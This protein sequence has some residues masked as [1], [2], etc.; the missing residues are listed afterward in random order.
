ME[1]VK[2]E[3][4]DRFLPRLNA[5]KTESDRSYFFDL[6]LLGEIITKITTLYLIANINEDKDRNK[7]RQEYTII[8]ANGIGEYATSIN[9]I[10]TGPTFGFLSS[11]LSD[12]EIPELNNKVLDGSWQSCAIKTM[13]KCLDILK[14][15]HSN[16]TSKPPFRSWFTLFSSLRN[17]TRGHGAP[18]ASMLSESCIYLEESL[19]SIIQNITIFKRPWAY[20]H[21]NL[22]GKYRVSPIC[23][24][25]TTFDHL[26]RN[27]TQHYE[28]GIYCH[29]D[30][31]RKINLLYSDA[32]LSNFY[33]PNG[34]FRSNT[35]EVLS[36]IDDQ[37]ERK[38]EKL[39]TIPP[40]KLPASITEGKLEL[41]AVHECFTNVPAISEEYIHRPELEKELT[42][43]LVD[44]YRYPVITLKGRGGIGK[45]SLALNIIHSLYKEYP[46]RYNIIIWFSARDV[47]LLINGPK[48][49]QSHVLTLED[50]SNEYCRLV[51]P[52]K[53][54]KTKEQFAHDLSNCPFGPALFVLDNFET[55]TNPVEVFDWIN[56]YIRNPNKVLITSRINRNFKADYP[57]EVSGMNEEQCRTL[58]NSIAIKYNIENL[59]TDSYIEDLIAESNGHPYIIKIILGEIARTRKPGKVNKIIADKDQ[60]LNALFRRTFQG[61]SP[62]AKRV[63]LTL[64]SWNSVIPKLA[65]EA[66]VYGS[67]AERIDI[68]QALDDL[69]KSSFI[70]EIEIN[71]DFFIN[72]PLAASLYGQSELAVYPEKIAIF[73]DRK[74]LMEFGAANSRSIKNGIA[75]LIQKKFQQ[76]ALRLKSKA[77]FEKEKPTLEFI[78]TKYPKA[79]LFIMDLYKS[80]DDYE[81]A[82]S[83]MREYLKTITL[84]SEKIKYWEQY[85]TLCKTT[86]D[87]NAESMALMEL[88]TIQ[89]VPF[90]IISNA[91]SRIN[92]Y[93]HSHPMDKQTEIRHELFTQL[94]DI[95]KLR[96]E[97]E[98]EAIDFSRLAWL[99]LNLGEESKAKLYTSKGLNR[100]PDDIHC[101]KLKD[102]LSI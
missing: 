35:F 89:D 95:M 6:L 26:K 100:D 64:C 86:N 88:A 93:F 14:I 85:V 76:V 31:I 15:E 24:I 97:K 41:D 54:K 57:I 12:H 21:Q 66:V 91:A 56:T 80:F 3:L 47:D 30:S 33:F 49:V 51:F 52:E 28:N 29:T 62:A 94:A 48:Q 10:L 75:S 79:W 44:E 38:E 9:D 99:Y 78:A 59:L 70:E 90:Y 25:G 87:W 27:N 20:L 98:G 69:Q 60:I 2:F 68:D 84:P 65:I 13:I 16:I 58:I 72:V 96:I 92:S 34:S 40:S 36:Y 42:S 22:S 39:Y 102:R 74:L 46:D 81:G 4:I 67:I 1:P 5:A 32:E 63:F 17:K 7:Y 11:A 101:L 61:L 53:I 19:T 77:L 23:N 43:V 71:D 55:I 18:T 37:K 73:Q 50:I 45:T 83:A 82:K 8:R